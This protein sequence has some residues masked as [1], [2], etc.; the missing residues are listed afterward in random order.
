[1]E[2]RYGYGIQ[3]ASYSSSVTTT[4]NLNGVTDTWRT[5]TLAAPVNP[6]SG[7]LIPFGVTSGAID[8]NSLR[9]FFGKPTYN[10]NTIA[11]NNLYRGGDLVP[12]I[13]QNNSIPN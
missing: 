8:M 12:D 5:T 3:V 13:T 11:M 9:E 2:V 6:S 1:M 10:S 4:L 7:T